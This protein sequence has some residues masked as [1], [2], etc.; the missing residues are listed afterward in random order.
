MGENCCTLYNHVAPPGSPSCAGIPFAI[1]P[2][3]DMTN[4]AMQ[5]SASSRH[6]GGVN[7]LMG[8]GGVHTVTNSVDL[9]VWRAL[10]TRNGRE[11]VDLP[12]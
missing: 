9:G 11:V 5:V 10:G 8:D 6:V 3:N 7:V 4:M 1:G 2:L 12:F